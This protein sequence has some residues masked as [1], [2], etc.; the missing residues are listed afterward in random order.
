MV[1][2]T[3]L[4]SVSKW[5]HDQIS[6]Y[7]AL[8]VFID[9]LKDIIK[10]KPGQGLPDPLMSESGKDIPCLKHSVNISLFSHR[11]AIGYNYITASYLSNK[12]EDEIVIV[13]MVYS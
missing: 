7:P 6:H 4:D 5:K 8:K 3:C 12:N 2:L 11:Y 13:K 10:K 9:K 1:N